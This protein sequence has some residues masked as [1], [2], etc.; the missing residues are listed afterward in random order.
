[1][2]LELQGAS[3][4]IT[5]ASGS[6]GR[7]LVR[8]FARE[9]ARLFITDLHPEPLEE[10]R[11][12]VQGEGGTCASFAAD[13][14][15][16]DE[17]RAATAAALSAWG[18]RID[19][20]V[21]GAGIARMGK[22][23]EMDEQAWDDVLNVNCKGTFLFTRE[24]VPH[25]KTQRRG[26]IIN[27]SSK[28][29]KTGSAYLSA[30]SAAKAAIIGFTQSLAHE[31]SS[32]RINVNCVCPGLV[33]HTAIG[34][35]LFEEYAKDLSVNVEEVIESFSKKI[36]LGRLARIDDVVDAVLFLAS[37]R[38]DYMTGQA[39]NVSGGREMH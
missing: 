5:G 33:D 14:T 37:S 13:V 29:G 11:R 15:R 21:N 24:V 31:L 38:S 36:P 35:E 12:E 18:D 22:I 6:I 10:L 3:V 30:Y 23:D 19:V 39:V 26:K 20:L 8:G 34:M 4:F 16:V 28:S 25:M 27:F 17:V 32:Y 9:G 2:D 7:G 1:M